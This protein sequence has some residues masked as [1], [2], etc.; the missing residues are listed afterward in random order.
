MLAISAFAAQAKDIDVRHTHW[1]GG[2]TG[3]LHVSDD[4]VAY[5]Q[6]SGDDKEHSVRWRWP[7]I[8]Q[9][10]LVR[11]RIVITSYRDRALLFG[12]DKPFEFE[13][14]GT[15]P[16]EDLYALFSAR[17]DQR[18]VARIALPPGDALWRLPAKRLRAIQGVEGELIVE[19]SRVLFVAT[20]TGE[21]RVWRDEDIVNISSS[22]PFSLSVTTHERGG[23]FEFQLK[24]P[25]EKA[26]YDELWKRLN[27]PR[28]L[29]LISTM[30]KEH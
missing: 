6:T 2:C 28:G 18:F 16:M 4:G 5:E 1:R 7:N 24:S 30:N 8:Q 21:S 25:I 23:N 3:V 14:T 19:R 17:M 22:G 13:F 15:P 9:L 26:R 10:D 20:A 27:G 12:S 29:D 11:D